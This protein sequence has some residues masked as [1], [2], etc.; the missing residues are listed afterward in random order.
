MVTMIKRNHRTGLN[1]SKGIHR[2]TPRTSAETPMPVTITEKH[3]VMVKFEVLRL[4]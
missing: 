1:V 2:W 4:S 3:K